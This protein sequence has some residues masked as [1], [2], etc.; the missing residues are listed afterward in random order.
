MDTALAHGEQE[1]LLAAL[2]PYRADGADWHALRS[3]QS[4]A[5][6][7]VSLHVL[8]PGQWSVHDGHQLLERIEADIRRVVPNVNVL[9]HLESLDDP[10]SYDDMALDRI[11]SSTPSPRTEQ[12]SS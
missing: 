4:G 10:A 6:R 1:A 11:Q 2:E 5:R 8:V 12:A 7:F 9:T 3:R